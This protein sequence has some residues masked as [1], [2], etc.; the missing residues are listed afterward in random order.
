MRL[1]Q[2]RDLRG[3]D[4]LDGG[5]VDARIVDGDVLDTPEHGVQT[6]SV[7]AGGGAIFDVDIA[8]PGLYPFVSHAFAS[9]DMGQVGVLKVGNVEGSMSH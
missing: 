9:A 4:V 2:R 7:P 3:V 6:V 8:K 5:T 1:P